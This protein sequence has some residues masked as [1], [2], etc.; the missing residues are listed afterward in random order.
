[1]AMAKLGL[2][3][4]R[5]QGGFTFGL[6]VNEDTFWTRY[7]RDLRDDCRALSDFNPG[8]RVIMLSS[9][10]SG[11][12]L[13]VVS[14]TESRPGEMICAWIHLPVSIAVS[15]EELAWILETVGEELAT[16][17]P[18]G[19]RLQDIFERD[20]PV[21]PVAMS[22]YKSSGDALAFRYYGE[23][24]RYQLPELLGVSISQP[25]YQRFKEVFF[26]DK[27]S[28]IRA[29]R[30]SDLA[31]RPCR[32]ASS[33]SLPRNLSVSGRMLTARCSIPRAVSPR[34]RASVSSGK[35][36]ATRVWRKSSM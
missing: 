3:I 15:G 17:S 35:G 16:G 23:G 11:N 29:D 19:G 2:K 34:G 22:V 31:I 4:T 20:Y 13:V 28:G 9:N 26:I 12:L 24:C 10:S 36:R 33:F 30:G 25:E 6:G 18:D 8:S 27:H 21:N 32:N 14:L 5:S 7:I 1:M